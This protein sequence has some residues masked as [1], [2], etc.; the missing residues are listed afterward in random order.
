MSL[1]GLCD[2]GVVGAVMSNPEE[3]GEELNQ[4]CDSGGARR[5]GFEREWRGNIGRT[6]L[7]MDK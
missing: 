4:S 2:K 3:N 1:T 6:C 5:A 7:Q